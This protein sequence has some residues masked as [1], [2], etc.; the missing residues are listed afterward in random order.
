[1]WWVVNAPYHPPLNLM[2]PVFYVVAEKENNTGTKLG[3][4]DINLF[5]CN[6]LFNCFKLINN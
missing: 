5:I 4:P 2:D 6:I 1:M 3:Y